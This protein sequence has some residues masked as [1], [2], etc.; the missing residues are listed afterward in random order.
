MSASLLCCRPLTRRWPVAAALVAM[1]TAPVACGRRAEPNSAPPPLEVRTVQAAFT[2]VA[3]RLEAG[4]TVAAAITATIGSRVMG[5]VRSIAI[6]PG[7][8]VKAGQT[9]VVLDDR[10][11]AAQAQSARSAAAAAEEGARAARAE[12]E[13][14]VAALALARSTHDRIAGLHE[15]RSATAQELDEAVAA[16]RAA[17]ARLSAADARVRQADAALAS[18]RAAAEAATVAASYATVTAPFDGLVTEKLVEPGDLVAPGRPLLRM[19]GGAGFRIDVWLDES[20]AALVAPGVEM[21]VAIETGGEGRGSTRVLRG[22]VVEVGRAVEADARAF[23]VKVALVPSEGLRSGMFARARFAGAPRQAL[24][25]PAEAVV[26]RGQ[27]ATAFVVDGDRARLRLVRIAP[28]PE[29]R[30]EVLSGLEAGEAVVVAPPPALA[31]GRP[32]RVVASRAGGPT[33]ASGGTR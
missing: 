3:D 12:R 8:H 13:G 18:A 30:V 28:A 31:D 27:V 1:A 11:L 10:D 33:P 24:T 20:R 25:I 2:T 15:R 19:D 5:T 26:T 22:T 9:L 7:D 32:V 29:G 6:A 23:R 16:L 21:D 4:G 17:E 14:A